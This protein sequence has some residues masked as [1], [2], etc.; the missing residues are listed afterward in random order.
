MKLVIQ[1]VNHAEVKVDGTTIGS[2]QKVFLFFLGIG[3]GDSKEQ[4]EYLVKKLVQL[5][6]FSDQNGKMNQS[7]QDIGGELLI[8]SQF[9]L[10]ADCHHGNR[11]SFT[12]AEEPSKAKML[13]EY[14]VE[15]CKK[16]NCSNVAT[17]EFGADMKIELENDGPVTIIL[18]H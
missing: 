18:E 15:T 4:V 17:G 12:P 3:K 1:R 2:I 7:I 13:Y 14:F 5:R 11:P 6:I 16:T 10:Y 9:T 8:V